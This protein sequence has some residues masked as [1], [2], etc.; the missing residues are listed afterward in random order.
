MWYN[1]TISTLPITVNG[2]HIYLLRFII[3]SVRCMAPFVITM[4]TFYGIVVFCLF[5]HHH[6]KLQIIS[7]LYDQRPKLFNVL[8]YMT[9]L[10]I[11]LPFLHISLQ[12]E[13]LYQCLKAQF[14]Q[15]HLHLQLL[16]VIVSYHFRILCVQNNYEVL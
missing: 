5:Y 2:F 8:K 15:L 7:L 16:D 12:L 11:F 1:W 3:R 6:L 13:L 14:R 10:I 9:K 4:M